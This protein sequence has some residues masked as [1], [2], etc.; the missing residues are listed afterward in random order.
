MPESRFSVL[1]RMVQGRDSLSRLPRCPASRGAGG[2]GT[3][4]GRMR[5]V[6][7]VSA[8]GPAC[9]RSGRKTSLAG[10]ITALD[11]SLAAQVRTP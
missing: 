8:G 11:A 4:Y 3:E 9:R 6:G 5:A 10:A 7:E 2:T 1:V